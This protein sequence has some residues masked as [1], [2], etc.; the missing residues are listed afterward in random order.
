MEVGVTEV[1][2][3]RGR[4]WSGRAV[5][6]VAACVLC[7][8]MLGRAAVGRDQYTPLPEKDAFLAEARK[9]LKS[10]ERL[11][12]QYTFHERQ[13]RIDLDGDGRAE[14]KT[15]KEFEVYPS[16]EGSPAYR[17]L[18]ATNGVPESP[19]KLEDAD[20]KHREKLL[21]W[22]HDRQA[23]SPSVRG[24]RELKE[25][26]GR[27]QEE[28]IM[29]DI[30]RVYDIR[31]VRRE[32]VRGRPAI[33]LTL[34]PR[35]GVKPSVEDAAPMTKLRGRAWVDERDFEVVRADLESTDTINLGWGLL[36]RIG[37]GTT[38]SLERQKVNDEVWLP[39]RV[40]AHPKARIALVKKVDAE[41]ISDYSDY[42]KFTVDMAISFAPAKPAKP[43]K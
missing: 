32:E 6:R 28:R 34:T 22:I 19:R 39:A 25:R 26:R 35:P 2:L 10:D 42:R 17:R 16:V 20:R 37:S 12:S 11:L 29:D 30:L 27:E 4:G 21:E 13:V 23:E 31:L 8:A 36:A 43:V 38:L 40:T 18:I 1:L 7:V 5:G 14:K 15:T 24:R 9:R 33:V 3:V 41:I